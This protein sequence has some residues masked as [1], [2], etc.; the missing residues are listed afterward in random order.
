MLQIPTPFLCSYEA[1]EIRS[2]P[3]HYRVHGLNFV[4]WQP[5]NSGDDWPHE[6]YADTNLGYDGFSHLNLRSFKTLFLLLGIWIIPFWYSGI[7][8][9]PQTASQVPWIE[10]V[11]SKFQK[12][13]STLWPIILF[14]CSQATLSGIGPMSMELANN[15]KLLKAPWMQCSHTLVLDERSRIKSRLQ[16]SRFRTP[17]DMSLASFIRW[18]IPWG[19]E[20]LLFFD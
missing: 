10:N 12:V 7:V 3:N 6:H 9:Q 4:F 19:S 8:S 11:Y 17:W 13:Y 1:W 18:H 5:L 20:G 15:P 16:L 2:T 14:A